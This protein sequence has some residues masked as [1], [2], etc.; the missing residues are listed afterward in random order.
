MASVL[1][2]GG[3]SVIE[4]SV[5]IGP[6]ALSAEQYDQLWSGGGPVFGTAAEDIEA[7]GVGTVVLDRPGIDERIDNGSGTGLSGWFCVKVKP[8]ICGGCGRNCRYYDDARHLIV[9]WPTENDP[10]LVRVVESLSEDEGTDPKVIEYE[11]SLGE[12]VSYYASC[13]S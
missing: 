5:T 1:D 10:N 13:P 8:F 9:V 3:E 4:L 2:D 7:G 11:K 6:F 12:A